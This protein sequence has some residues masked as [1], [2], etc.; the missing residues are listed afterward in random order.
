MSGESVVHRARAAA[1]IGAVWDLGYLFIVSGPG[2][3]P[4]PN[5]AFYAGFVGVM[6]A[7]SVASTLPTVDARFAQASRYAAA[8]GFVLAGAMA[9]ASIGLPLVVAGL[10]ALAA[11]DPRVISVRAGASAAALAATAFVAGVA[12]TWPNS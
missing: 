11:A 8:S 2:I 5:V 6:S 12:I 7:L 10:L 3:E 1:A 9:A 4:E